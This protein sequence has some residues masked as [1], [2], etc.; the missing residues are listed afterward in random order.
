MSKVDTFT[1]LHL[2]TTYSMLDGVGKAKDY[3]ERC[4]EL[5]MQ[6][7]AIT[8]HGTMA[9][10]YEFYTEMTKVGV[11][12]IIGNEMY[13]VEDMHQRG[14]TDKEK[15]GLTPTE[16]KDQ[17]KLRL[18]SPHLLLLAENDEGLRNLFRLNYY[19][20][21]DGYY[22]KPRIDLNLLEKHSDG[23]IATT[24]CVI[25][26]MAK[27]LQGKQTDKMSSF[28]ER[29]L[30]IFGKDNYF[31]EMH[32]HDLDIQKDY[33]TALIELFRKRY[34][35]VRCVLANDT[36]MVLKE[37]DK[38]HDF[39]F[40][41]STDGK[42]DEAGVHSLYLANEEEMRGL[43]YDNGYGDLISDE[44]LEE[45][46]ESTK[47]IASRCHATLDTETLKEPKFETPEG[48]KDNKE[49][50]VYQ[51]KKGMQEKIDAGHIT[52]DDISYYTESLKKELDLV[53]D[54]GYIDYFSYYSGFL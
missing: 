5:G 20:N 31:I 30:K 21:T 40:R 47:L 42:Y 51:L 34:E 44:Y 16:V 23:L 53:D 24:T 17:N 36:H 3:A 50:I 48:F 13:C 38:I 25:S 46:I 1:Q 7:C 12:P 43:W 19:A 11:K 9:G 18:R 52:E 26:N 45:A 8:D 41:M 22:G 33:N 39:L 10:V 54:K 28:F 32:P 27:Y 4:A 49:Y 2:H 37:H 6:A 35:D 14:L 29:M 15:S